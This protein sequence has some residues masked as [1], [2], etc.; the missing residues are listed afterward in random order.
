MIHRAIL[1]TLER[2]IGIL[3]ENTGGAFPLWLSP[4][5]I[6]VATISNKFDDY[7]KDV[8]NNL[9]ENGFRVKIDLRSEKINY[10]I[11]EH[12]LQKIPYIAIIGQKEVDENKISIREFGSKKEEV[13]S[14]EEFIKKLS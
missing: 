6:V 11:R 14:L 2:F 12:S 1:G 9:Q 5:Q 13:L 4:V 7:A 8:L 10:K 3:I